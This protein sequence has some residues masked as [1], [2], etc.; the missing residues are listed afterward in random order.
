MII[1]L[2]AEDMSLA[3]EPCMEKEELRL[4]PVS[5]GRAALLAFESLSHLESRCSKCNK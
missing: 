3:Q 2:V 5:P 4:A 1:S